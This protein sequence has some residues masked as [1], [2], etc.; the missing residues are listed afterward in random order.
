M[1]HTARE[2]AITGLLLTAV[3]ALPAAAQDEVVVNSGS[4][5]LGTSDVR[6]VS[7]VRNPLGT[8]AT[9]DAKAEARSALLAPGARGGSAVTSTPNSRAVGSF[10]LPFTSTRVVVGASKS[11]SSD[12]NFLATTFPYRAVGKLVF[13]AG[14]CTASVILR[15]VIVTAAHCV[16]DFG[17]GSALFSNF[18]FIP[19]SFAPGKTA[20]KRAPYGTWSW[21]ALARPATW[22]NGTDRGSESARDNDLAVL[23][24]EKNGDGKFIGDVTGKLGYSWNNYSFVSSSKT[25]N[26]SAA[27]VTTLGYPLLLDNGGRMQRTDGPAF[28]TTIKGAGQIWQGSNFTGGSSGGPWVVNFRAASPSF[29]AGA[30]PGSEANMAVIGVTS[31]GTSDPNPIKDNYSSQ[32]RQNTAYP[33]ASYGSYG[34]GNIGSLLNTVCK[35]VASGGKTYGQL[36]YCD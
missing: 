11:T 16:Q 4:A 26:L 8:P 25:G 35:K 18:Q 19:A 12:P 6:N 14:Y 5:R 32:F 2:L 28:L 30:G 15:S 9:D 34:A 24:L 13:S 23:V 1:T 33:K 10:G 20:A 17:T 22:A 36:G 29:S 3:Y 7:A 27:A 21:A 31:W